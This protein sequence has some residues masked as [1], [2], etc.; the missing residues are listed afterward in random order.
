M[1]VNELVADYRTNNYHRRLH[2]IYRAARTQS[3][4]E[5]AMNQPAP[6]IDLDELQ[7]ETEQLLSLLKNRQPGLRSWNF[8]MTCRLTNLKKL[9]RES[10]V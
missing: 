10:G 3:V 9:I 5:E 2:R 4:A 6:T 1:D 7:R 8:W